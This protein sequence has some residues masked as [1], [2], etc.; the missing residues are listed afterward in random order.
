MS[1]ALPAPVTLRTHCQGLA[2]RGRAPG[3]TAE[4]AHRTP[5]NSEEPTHRAIR[6]PPI[7]TSDDVFTPRKR[8]F[9]FRGVP[10]V[11][12]ARAWSIRLSFPFFGVAIGTGDCDWGGVFRFLGGFFSRT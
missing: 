10:R 5:K 1:A 4:P 8:Q 7:V 6:F 12:R 11:V 3:L 2:E 9:I